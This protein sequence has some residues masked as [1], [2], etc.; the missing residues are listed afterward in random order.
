M[1]KVTWSKFVEKQLD[2]IPDLIVRK[3]RVW[4]SLVEESGIREIRKYKGFHD[5]ALKGKRL[6]ERSVRLNKSYRAIYRE[7]FD[8]T[9]EL[10]EVL[11]VNKHEY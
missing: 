10:I 3:F 7:N 2:K 4:V 8:G 6:G 11:E 1:T 9:V 5:E